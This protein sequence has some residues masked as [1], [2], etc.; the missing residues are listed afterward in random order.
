MTAKYEFTGETKVEFGIT[1]RRIRALVSIAAAGVIVMK[2][3]LGGWLSSK[4]N[5]SHDGNAWV[6]GNA[7]VYGDAW[8]SGNARVYGDARV[9]GN[10]LVYGNA[11]V[12]GN[13]WVYGDAL[14]EKPIIAATR[15]DGYTFVCARTKDGPPVII[16]GCRY[17]TFGRARDHWQ[18]TRGGTKLGHESLL[19]VQ[20]LEAQA[21][22]QG[23]VEPRLL[24]AHGVDM[25]WAKT[26]E[27]T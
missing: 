21:E 24:T 3:D 16:A 27:A 10:A 25:P 6:S 26:R 2:G 4:K 11:R 18:R 8:V 20:Y 7:L 12:Y 19:I 14:V 9:Y 1:F 5:L 15:S 13:A 23:W 17:F 22:L